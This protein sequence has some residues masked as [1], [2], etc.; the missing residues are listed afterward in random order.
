[1]RTLAISFTN[2][3]PYHLARLRALA[4]ALEDLGTRLIA[5]ETAGTEGRYPWMTERHDEPFLWRTLFPNTR[6]EDL[7]AR[8]CRTAI[9]QVLNE[10]QP[11]VVA[12]VGYAR[13]ESHRALKWAER[14]GC[15]RIL[16]SESQEIDHPRVWWREAVKRQRVLR[17]TSALV[18][19]PRHRDYLVKLGM[20]AHQISMGYN[21]V[22]NDRYVMLAKLC[23]QAG[24]DAYPVPARP[25]FLSVHRFVPEKNGML[26]I[27]AYE[28]YRQTCGANDPWDLVLCGAGPSEPEIRQ[29]IL[30]SPYVS[31]IHLPGFLQDHDLAAFYTFASALVHPSL[32]EPWGLVVN[33]A[34]ACAVPLLI[35]N[36]AGCVQ[37]FVPQPN[38]ITGC[39]FDTTDIGELTACLTRMAGCSES[40]RRVMGQRA[41]EVV[42]QWGPDRFAQGL[43]QAWHISEDS[44]MVTTRKAARVNT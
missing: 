21:A 13:P 35:S 29:R 43:I 22:D 1:M 24:R 44:A 7:S 20:P 16:L 27:R 33:E 25:Y 11:D 41:T 37:T 23:R 38:W 14:R 30:S 31:S 2:F 5:Y 28:H 3:G 12:I 8:Q 32:M 39:Q 40:E 18:G 15:A 26:L 9:I 36:R 19:G 4:H 6:L 10:D 42:A 34:A 17:Y